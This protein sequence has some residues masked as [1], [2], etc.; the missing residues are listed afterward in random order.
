MLNILSYLL[1]IDSSCQFVHRSAVVN[2]GKV[3]RDASFS[4]DSHYWTDYSILK[5]I[6]SV[7]SPAFCLAEIKWKS[8]RF[9]GRCPYYQPLLSDKPTTAI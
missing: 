9:F 8:A 6:M 3:L 5:R 1:A 7:G 2:R 4:E